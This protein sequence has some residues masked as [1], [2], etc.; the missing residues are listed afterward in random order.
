MKPLPALYTAEHASYI[1]KEEVQALRRRYPFAGA[2]S[3]NRGRAYP[4]GWR[5]GHSRMEVGPHV[6]K[7]SL[8]RIM[9]NTHLA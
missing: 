1:V 5:E 7:C 9:C 3:A 2:G 4:H 6:C 8:E